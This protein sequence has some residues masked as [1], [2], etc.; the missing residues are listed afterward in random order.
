MKKAILSLIVLVI[1]SLFALVAYHRFPV[2]T[3]TAFFSVFPIFTWV[4][5]DQPV[6]FNHILHTQNLNLN[7]NFCHRYAGQYRSAGLPNIEICKACHATD[8]MSKRPEALK[9]VRYVQKG[10]EIPWEKMYDLPKFVVFPHSIH[11]QNNIDCSVCHGL[12]PKKERP[13]KMVDRN[14]MAWCMDCHQKRGASNDCYAC[15]SS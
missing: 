14:Y 15:H 6:L 11:V 2:R 4:S 8:A 1:I 3:K 10:K 12:T 9:V 5:I 13:V 7:C